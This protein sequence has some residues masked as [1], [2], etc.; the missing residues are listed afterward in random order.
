MVVVF[1]RSP[2]PSPGAVWSRFL[3]WCGP[4]SRPS[5]IALNL[6]VTSTHLH[7][8]H[9]HLNNFQY[10]P[11][12]D[13]FLFFSERLFLFG[14]HDVSGLWSAQ[15]VIFC[16]WLLMIIELPNCFIYNPVLIRFG[17][18]YVWFCNSC[19]HLQLFRKTRNL[20][21]HSI[22]LLKTCELV[23]HFWSYLPNPPACA[24]GRPFFS[25]VCMASSL[26]GQ[27][28]MT[29]LFNDF[30][31]GD[32]QWQSSWWICINFQPIYSEY[33]MSLKECYI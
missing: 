7:L 32:K 23:T 8:I 22:E 26:P 25:F 29:Y 12:T 33:H 6:F 19:C 31:S 16:R 13:T 4:L 5:V 9:L 1:S 17:K 27:N 3:S 11:L 30:V 14:S 15:I 20:L 21:W 10:R 28:I 2:L 24:I 18:C